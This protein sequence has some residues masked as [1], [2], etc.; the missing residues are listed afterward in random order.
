MENIDIIEN[1]ILRYD[2]KSLEILLLDRTTN[3]NIIWAC[4]EYLKYGELYNRTCEITIP[5]ITGSNTNII[6]PRITKEKQDK[7]SRTKEKAEVFT[8]SWICNAQNN[9][10][11]EKWFG[12]KDVF[13]RVKGKTWITT[14]TPIKFSKG[15]KWQD[16]V[17]AIRLEVTCGEA[18]YITSRYD[19][20]TGEPIALNERIGLLDRKLRIINENVFDKDEWIKWVKKAYQSIYGFEFQGDNLLLARESLFKTYI[21]NYS[22]KFDDKISK[23]DIREIATIISWNIW[24]MDGLKYTIPYT[25]P[26]KNNIQQANLFPTMDSENR[27]NLCM[28]KDWE[29]DEIVAFYTLVR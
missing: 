29:K 22:S 19:T 21:D 7:L 28:I 11:D 10:I 8:P 14:T 27:K 5:L 3:K 18:P 25:E 2:S 9:L 1:T 4:D 16:Y 12:K 23:K 20:V 24:Q 6:Q 26:P 17:S 13:N 15:K